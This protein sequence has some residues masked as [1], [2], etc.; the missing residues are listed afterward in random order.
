MRNMPGTR[1]VPSVP[2]SSDLG[3]HERVRA[4]LV[5]R[6]RAER[7]DAAHEVRAAHREVAG[8]DAAAAL[9]DQ[10]DALAGLLREALEPRLES[11]DQASDEQPTLRR[12]PA[13]RVW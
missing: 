9:A 1:P 7:D 13:R 3:E 11:I 6:R 4:E 12:I 10:R 2:T 8:E 5:D